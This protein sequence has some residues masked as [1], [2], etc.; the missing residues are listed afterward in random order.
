MDLGEDAL[1]VN[2]AKKIL[3]DDAEGSVPHA[4]AA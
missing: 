3:L 4:Q 2:L 1:T